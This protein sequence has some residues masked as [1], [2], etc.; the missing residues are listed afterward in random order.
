MVGFSENSSLVENLDSLLKG[1]FPEWP[2]I[3]SVDTMSR[4]RCE[5]ASLSHDI[6]KSAEMTIIDVDTIAAEDETKLR[7]QTVPDCLDTKDSQDL[8]DIV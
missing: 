5:D 1:T 4:D 3:N 7:Y 6:A 8:L 2:S